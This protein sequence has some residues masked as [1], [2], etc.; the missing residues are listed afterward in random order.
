MTEIPKNSRMAWS[1]A[2]GREV[3]PKYVAQLCVSWVTS[4]ARRTHLH[5]ASAL[6]SSRSPSPAVVASSSDDPPTSTR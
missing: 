1:W 5:M 3:V 2:T 6:D 4:I